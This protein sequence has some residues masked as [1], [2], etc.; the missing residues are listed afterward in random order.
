MGNTQTDSNP[1]ATVKLSEPAFFVKEKR[2]ERADSNIR[3]NIPVGNVLART[4]TFGGAVEELAPRVSKRI[5]KKKKQMAKQKAKKSYR[6][7]SQSP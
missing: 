5:E 6:E 1:L 3:S 7:Y 2:F 4:S